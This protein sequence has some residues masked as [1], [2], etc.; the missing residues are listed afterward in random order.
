M[1]IHTL[2]LLAQVFAEEREALAKTCKA[3]RE[4]RVVRLAEAWE[5]AA[6]GGCYCLAMTPY[7]AAGSLQRMMET[8]APPGLVTRLQWALQVWRPLIFN[9]SFLPL[10]SALYS[11]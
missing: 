8:E 3:P 1:Y 4:A 5:D 2:S 11:I 6:L 9:F 7:C 10:I